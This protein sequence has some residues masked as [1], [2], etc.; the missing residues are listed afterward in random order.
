MAMKLLLIVAFA[1][2]MACVAARSVPATVRLCSYVAGMYVHVDDN[3][4]IT[5]TGTPRSSSVFNLYSKNAYRVQFELKSKP[6]MFLMLKELNQS[7]VDVDNNTTSLP[8]NVTANPTVAHEYVLVVDY[9]SE[10]CLT[11][12]EIST[13]S[14]ALVQKVDENGTTCSIS[15][16][17]SGNVAGPCNLE[18]V[19]IDSIA[20]SLERNAHTYIKK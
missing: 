6:G 17:S 20:L 2:M 14:G 5:A 7:I 15:F 19:D 16:D 9:P 11:E 13:T 10:P 18:T 8:M 3:G 4:T 1:L 12:W